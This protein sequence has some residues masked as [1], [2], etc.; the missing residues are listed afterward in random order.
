MKVKQ[1]AILA[2]LAMTSFAFA[3]GKGHNKP[4]EKP[5]VVTPSDPT[6]SICAWKGVY[7]GAALNQTLTMNGSNAKASAEGSNT[8]ANNNI[9]SNTYGV[10]IGAATNQ[11]ATFNGSNVIAKAEG[12]NTAAQNNVASNIGDVYVATALNQTATFNG[13]NV[14]AVAKGSNTRAVQNLATNNACQTCK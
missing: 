3:G 4:P 8:S 9:A 12:S 14:V 1:L 6:C 11:T 13:S 7:V 10:K 5:P 2:T